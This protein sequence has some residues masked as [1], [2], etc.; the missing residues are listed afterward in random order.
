MH[1]KHAIATWNTLEPFQHLAEERGKA[2]TAC[3]QMVGRTTFR[4]HTDF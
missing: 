1:K 4:M 3:V 2:K